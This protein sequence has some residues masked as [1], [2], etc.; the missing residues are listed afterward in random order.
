MQ[1]GE[2]LNLQVLFERSWDILGELTNGLLE[3]K[4]S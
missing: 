3:E 2:G 1:E 4:S